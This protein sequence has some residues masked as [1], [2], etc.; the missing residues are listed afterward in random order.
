MKRNA[1]SF[2]HGRRIKAALS[3]RGGEGVFWGI[4]I[5]ML[6][7]AVFS[8]FIGYGW[9]FAPYVAAL[10]AAYG[11]IEVASAKRFSQW[12]FENL[13]KGEDAETR[14]GQ[15]IEYV[16][17]REGCAVAHSVTEISKVGDIDH[18]VATPSAIWVIETKYKRVPRKT[19]PEVLSRI[20]ANTASVRQ[21]APDG[22]TVRGCLV[23]A[24]E[25]SIRKRNYPYRTEQI[26]AFTPQQ[27]QRELNQEIQSTRSLDEQVA[28]DIWMLG[29]SSE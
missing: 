17:T 26:T 2:I 23:L 3:D 4:A 15:L 12:N 13:Q 14:I 9:G 5:G 24:Y 27:L 20:A 19:F 25:S 29:H 1:G 10:I 8:P 16:L 6:L 18:I 11:A 22:T 21:W 28:K 7:Y